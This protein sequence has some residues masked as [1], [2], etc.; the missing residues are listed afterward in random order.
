[1]FFD[2][3]YSQRKGVTT[4]VWLKPKMK[5]RFPDGNFYL[6]ADRSPVKTL[7]TNSLFAELGENSYMREVVA[8]QVGICFFG[9]WWV[10]KA[11]SLDGRLRC[12]SSIKLTECWEYYIS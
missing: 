1:M 4:L 9:G 2:N 7:K 10:N 12:C 8:Y 5:W 6:W 11:E 3:I